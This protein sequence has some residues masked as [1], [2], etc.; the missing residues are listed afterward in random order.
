M[1]T[2][3]SSHKTP[4]MAG[5]LLQQRADAEKQEIENMKYQLKLREQA[6][7]VGAV[8]GQHADNNRQ[9]SSYTHQGGHGRGISSAGSSASLTSAASSTPSHSLHH[10]Q[11]QPQLFGGP[12]TLIEQGE[13]RQ[14]ER[15][16]SAGT[17]LLRPNNGANTSGYSRSRSKSRGPSED[18]VPYQGRST[19]PHSPGLT[20]FPSQS[21][22]PPMPQGPLL[23][24]ADQDA[25][26]QPG[27]LLDR[28]KSSKKSV[29]PSSSAMTNGY[30]GGYGSSAQPR[31]MGNPQL[32]QSRGR[33]PDQ[34]QQHHQQ[35]QGHGR[36]RAKP[37]VD[38]GNLNTSQDVIRPGLLT[39][40]SSNNTSGPRSARS[41]RRQKP[42][43][44][45]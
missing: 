39:N 5:S 1:A 21:Y 7:I 11:S 45:F 35:Q 2:M 27:L 12:G 16:K 32:Q 9:G 4:F 43:L 18:R 38:L 19:S 34:G 33:Q 44:D 40:A 42:L 30:N 22:T 29:S 37:L 24:F 6:G 14:L 28:A 20:G 36:S 13:A 15:S 26:I 3:A 31:S 17:G 8:R 25:M 41:P 23:H 10:Q